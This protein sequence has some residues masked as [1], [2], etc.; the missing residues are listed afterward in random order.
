MPVPKIW[1]SYAVD[2]PC[3]KNWPEDQGGEKWFSHLEMSFSILTQDGLPAVQHM[4]IS[5]NPFYT[6]QNHPKISTLLHAISAQ[7]FLQYDASKELLITRPTEKMTELLIN[8]LGK[9]THDEWVKRVSYNENNKH[10]VVYS[11]DLL[12]IIYDD[13]YPFWLIGHT[14]VAPMNILASKA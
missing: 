3:S 11:D 7:Y 6:G 13:I 9:D 12:S 1:V 8:F 5:R 10:L 14:V 4:G 2:F